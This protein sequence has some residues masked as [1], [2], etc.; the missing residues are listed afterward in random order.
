[1]SKKLKYTTEEIINKFRLIHGDEYDYSK[2]VYKG[3]EDKV[4]IGCKIHGY[5]WKSPHDHIKGQ[6][7]PKCSK[8]RQ[9]KKQYKTNEAFKTE[10]YN[11]YGDNLIL[12]KINYQGCGV[13]VYAICPKHGGFWKYPRILLKGRGCPICN[14]SLLEQEIIKLLNDNNITFIHQYKPKF[15]IEG[16]GHQS[17]DFYIPNKHIAIECQ[18]DQHYR[19]IN[20][21]GGLE[22]LLHLQ[23]LD[24]RKFDKC[25]ENGIEILYY[26]N[27]QI[28]ETIISDKN[29]LLR[30][31]K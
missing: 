23:E 19:P 16:K 26:S 21:Y 29:E 24:K 5:F 3:I 22:G 8:I 15:L 12:D 13:K 30:K 2:V 17:L 28:D 4:C 10:L 6:K 9:N 20:Y 25:K 18:G 11:R 31:I 7:C 27:K 14:C 1:M